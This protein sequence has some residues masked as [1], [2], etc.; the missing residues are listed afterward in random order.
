M[1][2]D[3]YND[4]RKK[5]REIAEKG[6]KE[7]FESP[8]DSDEPPF[9]GDPNDKFMESGHDIKDVDDEVED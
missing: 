1:M 3:S 2:T 6:M 9:E 8:P 4:R 7:I 5:M